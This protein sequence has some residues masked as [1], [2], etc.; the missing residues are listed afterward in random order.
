MMIDIMDMFQL[1]FPDGWIDKGGTPCTAIFSSKIVYVFRR[2]N[3]K[4]NV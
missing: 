4:S 1:Y 2:A 3:V